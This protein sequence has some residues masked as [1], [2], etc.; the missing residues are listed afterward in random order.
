MLLETSAVVETSII[1]TYLG[2]DDMAVSCRV[3]QSARVRAPIPT[4][5]ALFLSPCFGIWRKMQ[6]KVGHTAVVTVVPTGRKAGVSASK[7]R[8]AVKY[9]I[10]DSDVVRQS[11]TKCRPTVCVSLCS[12][13]GGVETGGWRALDWLRG[14]WT[15]LDKTSTR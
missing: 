5:V 8:V 6:S 10:N 12:V 1:I 15:G 9:Q 4:L 11:E 2:H 13:G 14:E 3:S 7:N